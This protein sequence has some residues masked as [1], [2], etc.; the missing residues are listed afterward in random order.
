MSVKMIPVSEW[1]ENVDV[2]DVNVLDLEEA[3]KDWLDD[4]VKEELEIYVGVK[5]KSRNDTRIYNVAIFLPE[6]RAA[7][8]RL[9]I[10][11][12]ATVGSICSPSLET[13][14]KRKLVNLDQ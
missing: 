7:E 1:L 3:S 9:F 11:L 2:E 5:S 8:R 4:L 14:W 12:M 13:K 6:D 10:F